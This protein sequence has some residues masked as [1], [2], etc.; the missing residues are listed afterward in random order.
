MEDDEKDQKDKKDEGPAS[1]E[2]ALMEA[3][4]ILVHGP[5]DDKLCT[6]VVGRLLA[7]EK[8]DASAPVTLFINSPGG[9]ADAGFAIYDLIRFV[10][11]P[12]R[13]VVNGLCASAAVLIHL[14]AEKGQR[15]A[16]PGSR[17]LIHQ[18]STQG[19]GSASDLDITAQQIV[20]IRERYNQI[21]ADAAGKKAKDVLSDVNRDFWLDAEEAK[22]YGVVDKVLES[23]SQLD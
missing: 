2:K 11:C 17:F 18:P 4:S 12:V 19:Q 22:K 5:V 7:L 10:S 16:T 6:S 3:R 23:R 21:V 8:M 1:A 14:G 15:F 20:K 9:S 13:C